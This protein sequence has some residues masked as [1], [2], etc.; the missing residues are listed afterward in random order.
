MI[1]LNNQNSNIRRIDELG[2]I[3]I[4]KDI[5]KK[6]YIKDNE[7]LEIF[8]DNGEIRIKKYSVLPD[9]KEYLNYLVDL[10]MRLTDNK[11]IITD[12]TH[13]IATSEEELKD[14]N[15]SQSLESIVLSG[16]TIKNEKKELNITPSKVIDA[17]IRVEPI[18]I[19]GDRSGVLIEYNEN[20]KLND[21]IVIK[22]FKNLIEKRLNN[23]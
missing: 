10:G 23:C 19:E 7:P 6:L 12:R 17:N 20:K 5:R 9:I 15:L 16:S 1:S 8:I 2:R 13:I 18:M 4:P 21:D 3:V 14:E 11:Y 22:I